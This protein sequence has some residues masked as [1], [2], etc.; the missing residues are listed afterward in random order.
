MNTKKL[1]MIIAMLLTLM[2]I[3]LSEDQ[4]ISVPIT[5]DI[6]ANTSRINLN[7]QGGMNTL[8]VSTLENYHQTYTLQMVKNVTCTV[9]QGV[10]QNDFQQFYTRFGIFAEAY[11]KTFDGIYNNYIETKA[12]NSRLAVEKETLQA[13][14]ESDP[15][16]ESSSYMYQIAKEAQEEAQRLRDQAGYK[17]QYE[18]CI[19]E[20]EDSQKEKTTWGIGGVILGALIVWG[21]MRKPKAKDDIDPV[22]Y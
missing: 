20:K 21:I 6:N 2:P 5:M 8:D 9:Q 16:N 13:Q 17:T 4:I 18:N 1:I 15:N 22:D 19:K 14:I 7:I 3:V 12:T 11:N 10:S